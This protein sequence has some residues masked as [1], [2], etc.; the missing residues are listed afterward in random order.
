MKLFGGSLG[1]PA[2]CIF[3]FQHKVIIDALTAHQFIMCTGFGDD[4]V[5]DNEDTVRVAYRAESVGDHDQR[6][7]AAKFADRLLDIRRFFSV[8]KA[9]IWESLNPN[10]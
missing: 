1:V 10:G 4:P 3:S 8:L 2:D 7:A 6:F 5:F 9:A